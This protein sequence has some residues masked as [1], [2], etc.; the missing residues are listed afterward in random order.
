MRT[1]YVVANEFPPSAVRVFVCYAHCS[2]TASNRTNKVF[3]TTK[4][5]LMHFTRILF[6]YNQHQRIDWHT[7]KCE[8]NKRKRRKIK[9]QSSVCTRKDAH[10]KMLIWNSMLRARFIHS[11][12]HLL[13]SK[14]TTTIVDLTLCGLQMKPIQKCM[15]ERII[16]KCGASSAGW[17]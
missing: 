12:I 9:V 14:Q 8:V 16:A 13:H 4:G 1:S 6:I 2:H 5:N 3:E 17:M 10:A 7:K 11:F 15:R